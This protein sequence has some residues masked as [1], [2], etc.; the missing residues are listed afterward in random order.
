MKDLESDQHF[1]TDLSFWSLL[2]ANVITMVWA[3]K[4]GWSL[5]LVIWVYFCQNLIWGIFWP[6]KI[7]GVFCPEKV[8]CLIADG[9]Y[10]K[11][12]QSLIVFFGH[13][14][15][16]HVGYGMILCTSDFFGKG[17]LANFKY[18]LIMGGFFFLSEIVSC[19]AESSSSRAKPLNLATVQLFPYA[20]LLPMHVIMFVGIKLEVRGTN[21]H[22]IVMVFLLLKGFADI[23]MYLVERYSVFANL[24]TD[25]FVLPGNVKA[26]EEACE[27]CQRVI[28]KDEIPWSIKEHV[29]C[30]QCYEKLEKEVAC[31]EK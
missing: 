28:D 4:E 2:I 3:L 23:A 26:K 12:M 6:A 19:F 30:K 8:Y 29:V 16:V 11:K 7:L 24:A 14:L 9:S 5:S 18:I 31:D 21:P 15:A 1:Y 22:L 13:Y 20:R 10:T 25:F 17:L 27:L